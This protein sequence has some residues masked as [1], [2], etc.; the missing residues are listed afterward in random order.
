MEAANHV[1]ESPGPAQTT[2]ALFPLFISAFQLLRW[3]S[4]KNYYDLFL[5]ERKLLPKQEQGPKIECVILGT[6]IINK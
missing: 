3:P 6:Y 1:K 4:G 2:E 5:K